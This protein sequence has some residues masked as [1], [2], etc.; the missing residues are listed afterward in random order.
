MYHIPKQ[1]KYVRCPAL[2]LLC[3]SLC[4]P[5]TKMFGDPGSKGTCSLAG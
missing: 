3:D 4:G 5:L 2:E 1:S